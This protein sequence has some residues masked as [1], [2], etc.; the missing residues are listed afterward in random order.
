MQPT[1]P[2][3]VE[4]GQEKEQLSTNKKELHIDKIVLVDDEMIEA[5]KGYWAQFGT[6]KKQASACWSMQ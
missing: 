4:Q 2:D 3:Y 1:S 6:K 5:F